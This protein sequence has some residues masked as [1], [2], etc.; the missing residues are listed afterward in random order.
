MASKLTIIREMI[1]EIRG[2]KVML[3]RDLAELYGVELK[4]LNEAV[5]RN[6][7]RFP[8]DFMLQ[9]NKEEWENLRS[10]NATAN[11]NLSKVRFL[12]YVFT[13][14]GV[15]M[16]SNVLNTTKAI[17]M[18]IQIICISFTSGG[19]SISQSPLTACPL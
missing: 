6:I 2:Q 16:L 3:D 15:L 8:S 5:K 14:H 18:S 9:L 7:K 13:E 1:Y 11:K 12:P 19:E 10:Q 17:N 4:R